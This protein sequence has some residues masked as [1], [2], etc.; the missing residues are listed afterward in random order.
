[1]RALAGSLAAAAVLATALALLPAAPDGTPGD[2]IPAY[3]VV[4]TVRTDGVVHVHETITYDFGGDERG[5]V[6]RVRYRDGRRVYGVR[7]VRTSSSTGA[8]ARARVRT[9]PHDV[10]IAVGGDGPAVRGR[11]A[12]VIEYDLAGLLTP[13][14]D[15]DE[16]VWDALGASWDV[17]VDEA[18][19]R[20][21]APARFRAGCRAG[22][23]P[24]T[25]CVRHRD[26]PFA[27]VF[28]Q[29]DLAPHE[30]MLIRARLP[31]GAVAAP[32]PRY[33]PPRWR[34]GWTGVAALVLALTALPWTLRNPPVRRSAVP[35]LA[36]L[37]LALVAG[38]LGTA[39]VRDGLWA[40]SAGDATPTGAA[41][42]ALAAGAALA[43]TPRRSGERHRV[44]R[45][46]PIG[47]RGPRG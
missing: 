15:R 32:P 21:A 2:R 35:V 26:G 18:A 5:I 16:L 30:G 17:P 36:G 7:D 29:R 1:M 6:R 31:K 8:P 20:I 47:R 41:L 11:Q 19:V 28:S 3:D 44:V 24:V 9:L 27:L 14:A 45:V 23:P 43:G 10:R 22:D 4:L 12:Y 42:L 39:A 37:G 40:V 25:R 13:R 34:G 46:R 38:D 33:A